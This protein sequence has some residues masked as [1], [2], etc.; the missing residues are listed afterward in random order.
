M[1]SGGIV[2]AVIEKRNQLVVVNENS[3]YIKQL[4]HE[5][6]RYQVQAGLSVNY[7]AR[8]IMELHVQVYSQ[9]YELF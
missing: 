2:Q 8:S 7:T 5:D 3:Y 1:G 4:Y 6:K 9:C